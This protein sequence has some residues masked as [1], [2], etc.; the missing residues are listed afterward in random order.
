MHAKASETTPG[1]IAP[2]ELDTLVPCGP[3]AAFDYFTRDVARWWPLS[4]YSCALARAA[5]VAFDGRVGGH[6][7]ETDVDGKRY[8]WGTVLAWEPGRRIA[9]TWHPTRPPD[10]ALK[11]EVTFQTAGEA[12]RVRLVHGGWDRLGAGAAAMREGYAS[13]WPN[14]LGRLYKGYCERAEASA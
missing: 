12:T 6:L 8:V 1:A 9:F 3:D 14:V 13:G 10:D 2:I 5:D 7:T 4:M 11:V